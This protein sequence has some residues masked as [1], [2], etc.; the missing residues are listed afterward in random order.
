VFGFVNAANV[1][2]NALN[3][4]L[5][6]TAARFNVDDILTRDVAGFRD[7]VR[8]RAT[9][10]ITRADIG[11][12]V[13]DVVDVRSIPPRFLNGA[14]ESVLKAEVARSKA[15][16]EARTHENQVLSKARAD[17]NS[18]VNLAESDRVRVVKDTASQAERFADILPKYR[19]NPTLFAQYRLA[20]TVG[21]AMTNVQDKIFLPERADGKTRE[22]R[23]LLNR[24]PQKP[25]TETPAQ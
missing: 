18:L 9:E 16:N 21:R 1:I 8:N 22:L 6:Y 15:L 17:A 4:A 5:L 14:F 25:K 13:E 20:E 23:L 12:V 19:A 10:L 7:A 24:E 2:Q 3:E 11:V